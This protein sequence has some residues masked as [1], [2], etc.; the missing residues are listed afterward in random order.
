[1]FLAEEYITSTPLHSW[2]AA[3]YPFS[4]EESAEKYA[5]KAYKIIVN[6]RHA[7][8]EIHSKKLGWE[9]FNQ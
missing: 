8:H 6:L 3:Y 9:I 2:I 4:P 7:V 5:D 1:M